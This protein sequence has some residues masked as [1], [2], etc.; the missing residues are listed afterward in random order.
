MTKL[1]KNMH[2]VKNH[3][4]IYSCLPVFLGWYL[5]WWTISSWGY[6]LPSSQCFGT[7]MVY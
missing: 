1:T 6:N 4:I 5:C 2:I 3:T 7:D